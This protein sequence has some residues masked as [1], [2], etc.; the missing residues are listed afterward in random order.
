MRVVITGGAGLL[1]AHLSRHLTSLG[2]EV[3]CIDNLSGGYRE[4]VDPASTF[5][6]V[7]LCE[8]HRVDLVFKVF[9][10][11]VVFHFAAFAA[12]CASP[13]VRRHTFNNNT[14]ATTNVVNACVNNGVRKL[15][16]ASS[17][18][19]YGE[20]TPPF[21]ES[22]IPQPLDP[23]GIAKYASEL[24]IASASKQFGL[25]YNIVRPHNVFGIYQNIWDRYRNVIGIWITKV[26]RDQ[27]MLVYGEGTQVRA[28][29]DVQFY[30]QP[31]E[32]LMTQ[33]SG[34][35]FNIGAENPCTI[36][37]LA[38]LVAAVASSKGY[39]PVIEHA[40]PRDEVHTAY[41]NHEKAK[42]LLGFFDDT[43]I[44]N[45]VEI[46]FD[47]ARTQPQRPSKGLSFEIQEGV[48]EYWRNDT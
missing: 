16:F 29:S 7:D 42:K 3:L 30:M 28:F 14:L 31:F 43:N 11:E 21:L 26:M 40:Q 33:H 19:V 36:L 27:P 34:E 45:L 25:E 9:K 18:D 20:A 22:M 48:Y 2:H 23:Y 37:E 39:N 12:V 47:W 1:G 46:M 15:V 24:D 41:C 8:V 44:E 10:P 5:V 4:Y 13:F 38:K 35:T 6:C 17:M 32:R